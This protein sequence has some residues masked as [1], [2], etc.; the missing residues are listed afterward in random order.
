MNGHDV[1]LKSKLTKLEKA[2]GAHQDRGPWCLCDRQINGGKLLLVDAAGY[3]AGKKPD[4]VCTTCG[5]GL[6]LIEVVPSRREGDR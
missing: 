2:V 4:T 5:K 6:L 3:S 1:S